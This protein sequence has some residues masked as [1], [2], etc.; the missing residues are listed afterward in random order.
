MCSPDEPRNEVGAET[1]AIIRRD[2]FFI[3][4]EW[5]RHGLE[6]KAR[7]YEPQMMRL[8]PA[9]ADVLALAIEEGMGRALVVER[10]LADHRATLTAARTGQDAE[11]R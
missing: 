8:S 5:W 2:G 10:A 7:L 4:I 3:C 6:R 1:E 9:L 11:E